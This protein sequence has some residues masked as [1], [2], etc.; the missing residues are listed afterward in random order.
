L[1]AADDVGWPIAGHHANDDPPAPLQHLEPADAPCV[2]AVVLAMLL[3]VVLDGDFDV[4]P[5]HVEAGDD[6]AILV[7]FR[8]R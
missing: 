2:L 1:Y 4:L 7:M 8:E 3:S 5:T 6:G